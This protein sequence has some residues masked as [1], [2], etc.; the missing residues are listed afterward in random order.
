[1]RDVR[2]SL[3][4]ATASCLWGCAQG[5]ADYA[6]S[7]ANRGADTEEL[8]PEIVRRDGGAQRPDAG[9][10][11]GPTLP[12]LD[13]DLDFE[14]ELEPEPDSEEPFIDDPL[15]VDGSVIDPVTDA[16]L[17]AP[18]LTAT[19]T[20]CVAGAYVG[21]FRGELSALNGIV[22]IDVV[23]TLHFD[24]PGT[25]APRLTLNAGRL[26]GTD[27][28]GHPVKA[29]LAGSIACDTG[30]LIDGKI[31]AGTYTRPDPVFRGR[32]T[33]ARFAGVLAGRFTPGERPTAR[34]TWAVE[35]ERTT[36]SGTGSFEVQ[37]AR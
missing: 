21:T 9:G 20:S 14:P 1:M 13:D 4:L 24:L 32:T 2:V 36:R 22:R 19:P 27:A 10:L 7:N 28:D 6:L 5:A 12:E 37:L 29:T 11:G 26:E 30:E 8:T 15:P 33:T 17:P 23:G 35:S 3:L 16:A 34:G 31:L 25:E 18:P